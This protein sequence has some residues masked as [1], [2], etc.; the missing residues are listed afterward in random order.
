MERRESE[1]EMMERGD[2]ERRK[3]KRVEKRER[4]RERE[5]EIT[6]KK[7]S[8]NKLTRKPKKN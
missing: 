4:E 1:R 6:K 3:R 8:A 2:T 5:R 7:N